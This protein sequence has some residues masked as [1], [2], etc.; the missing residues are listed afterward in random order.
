IAPPIM[1]PVGP[2]RPAAP[3]LPA[4]DIPLP[5]FAAIDENT[6]AAL[7]GHGTNPLLSA[8]APLLALVTRLRDLPIH[9]DVESLRERVIAELRRFETAGIQA[10]VTTDQMRVGRYA[11][12][13]TVDDVVLNTPWGG[14][15]AWAAKSMVTSIHREAWGGERFF[16]LLEQMQAEP[17]R[18]LL[19]LELF[20]ACLSLGF[21]GRYRVSPRGH[22]DLARLRDGLYR[23]LRRERGDVDRE[24]SPQWRGV[25]D[26]YRP[27]GAVAPL[28][29]V[30]AVTAALLMFLYMALAYSLSGKT[31]GVYQKLA[32]LLPNKPVEIAR[33][34]ALPPAPRVDVGAYQR[35]AQALADDIAAGR[36]AVLDEGDGGVMVRTRANVFLSGS[37]TIEPAYAPVIDRIGKALA[38]ENGPVQVVGHTDSQPIRTLRFPSNQELSEARA[39]AV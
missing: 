20:Y 3:P 30:G 29:V 23:V 18:H 33:L 6:L 26:R 22:S 16:D 21:E 1:P 8:A 34:S 10:G 9:R 36:L 37:D 39:Q 27:L 15:S 28:W 17:K 24:L 35:I 19:E 13:A 31:D 25:A 32:G 4:T 38:A 7:T 14:Q 2:P 11:L 5:G 12:C